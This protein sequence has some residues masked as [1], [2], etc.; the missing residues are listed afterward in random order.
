[1]SLKLGKNVKFDFKITFM[2]KNRKNH[3]YTV[4][5]RYKTPPI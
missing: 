2:F 4:D 3:T 1:M 5:S